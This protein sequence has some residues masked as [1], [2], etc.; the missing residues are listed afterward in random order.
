MKYAS[1]IICFG[2]MPRDL[3]FNHWY[4]TNPGVFV[5]PHF[6]KK[7]SF[8]GCQTA[9][10]FVYMRNENQGSLATSLH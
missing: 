5:L 1:Y 7:L 6:Q 8:L 2:F 3:Y 9:S 10:Q 4:V